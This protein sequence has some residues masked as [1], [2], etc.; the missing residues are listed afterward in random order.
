V[1][2]DRL[3][4]TIGA[5]YEH[6]AFSGGEFQPSARARYRLPRG[7][8]VWGAVSRA[9]RRPTRFDDDILAFGPAGTVLARGSDDFR[10]ESLIAS[11][12]GY[13]AQAARAVSIDA[14]A[15][16]HRI[17]DLRSQD[18][19][20]TGLPIVVGNSL[21]GE[22]H[23]V[24]FGVNV[25]PFDWWRTHVAYTWL[26]TE[27]RRA[28]GSRDVGGGASEANDP[29]HLFGVRTSF[30]LPHAIEVDAMLRSIGSLPNP[31][32]PAFTEL[33]LRAGWQ[34]TPRVQLW[35]AG[36]DLLH[37]RHPEF[38]P[39]TPARTEFERSVR[40]GLTYRVGR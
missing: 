28:P 19:P 4:A 22:S 40:I 35:V 2:S 34:A 9:V 29:H 12:V 33:D 1:L 23:G 18:L 25:Q 37:D 20:P 30:D 5:K 16:H 17:T 27:I 11:E 36:R 3:F 32:V 21:E 10:A 39:D 7:Q 15:F 14:T 6:N 38:G 24:E 13:R 26:D 31:R 8:M